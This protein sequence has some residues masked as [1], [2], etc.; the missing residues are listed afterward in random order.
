M[1]CLIKIVH[2]QLCQTNVRAIRGVID[3]DI[4]A[5]REQFLCLVRNL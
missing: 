1:K 2:S 5:I 3:N 4:D